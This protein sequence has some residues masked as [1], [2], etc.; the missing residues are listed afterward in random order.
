MDDIDARYE[1]HCYSQGVA[2]AEENMDDS[3]LLAILFK[4]GLARQI[5]HRVFVDG[6]VIR[7][8]V[9]GIDAVAA[10]AKAQ[11]VHELAKALTE[12]QVVS[13]EFEPAGA[14][15]APGS[16]TFRAVLGVLL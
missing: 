3:D 2:W 14:D 16:G 5:E 6:I 11:A 8:A 4:R 9:G 1:E 10:R 12:Q 15:Y 7:T 13:H